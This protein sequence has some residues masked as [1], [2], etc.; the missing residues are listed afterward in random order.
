MPATRK[1]NDVQF[2]LIAIAF[3]SAFNYYLTY[4]NIKFN[5]FLLLTYTIDT[6]QG[7]LAWFTLRSI[8]IYLDRKMP[9]SEGVVKRI[10]VQVLVTTI[11]GLAVIILLTEMVSWIARGRSALLNFYTFDIFIIMIW[12][13]VMNGIYIGMHYYHEWQESER[14]R[15]EDKKLRQDGFAIKQGNQKLMIAFGDIAGFYSEN[16]YTFLQTWQEKKYLAERSLDKS[17]ELLPGEL[18]FRLN[19]QYML[20]RNAISG[21]KKA[22]DG[23]I[24]ILVK[25]AGSLPAIVSVSRTKAV[26]FKKW[27]GQEE[28]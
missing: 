10:V 21:Y 24:D 2:F 26:Q 16:G 7:W 18:F 1:Y 12:F 11:A 3:I 20:H 19:R 28:A 9:Y 13:F 17:E 25:P 5:G 15:R 6:V 4:S 27:F 23:K 14:L 8:V 22:N